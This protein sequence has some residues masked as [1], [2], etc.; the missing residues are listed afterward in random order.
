[1]KFCFLFYFPTPEVN[2]EPI[3]GFHHFWASRNS[4]I[5]MIYLQAEKQLNFIVY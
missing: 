1:M 3:K 4:V 2:I 5:F